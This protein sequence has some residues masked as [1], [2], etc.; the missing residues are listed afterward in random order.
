MFCYLRY[1][2]LIA[3]A[4]HNLFTINFNF[5]FIIGKYLSLILFNIRKTRT[6]RISTCHWVPLFMIV[7]TL[8]YLL[9]KHLILISLNNYKVFILI[10]LIKLLH[11]FFCAR[12]SILILFFFIKNIVADR[13]SFLFLLVRLM[14]WDK[15]WLRLILIQFVL[16]TWLIFKQFRRVL[17]LVTI[18][19]ELDYFIFLHF[20]FITF[21]VIS[22]I[23]RWA[24]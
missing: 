4:E 17:I 12:G 24:W 13:I 6:R 16:A 18:I 22:T 15:K 21:Q 19:T 20:C 5:G 8:S 10:Q 2:Q 23:L 7:A 14:G 3:V 11:S 9:A 1:I